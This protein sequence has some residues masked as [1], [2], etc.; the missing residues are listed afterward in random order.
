MSKET[1]S[2]KKASE[3]LEVENKNCLKIKEESEQKMM[4]YQQENEKLKAHYEI[5][6][7]HELNII[8]DY[9]SKKTKEISFFEQKVQDLH[10]Q[11]KDESARCKD[12]E[13]QMFRMREEYRKLEFENEKV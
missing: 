11:Y 4:K 3:L 6:K 10:S 7:D 9:E 8:K 5:L 12:L 2:L 13:E 1:D